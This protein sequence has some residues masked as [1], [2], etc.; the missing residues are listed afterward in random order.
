M[1]SAYRIF[2]PCPECVLKY[3]HKLQKTSASYRK[4]NVKYNA[5][6]CKLHK[7]SEASA[8]DNTQATL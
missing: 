4:K 5:K 2:E 1:M 6:F 3:R 8:P 7:T